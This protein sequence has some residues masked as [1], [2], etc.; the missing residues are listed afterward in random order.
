MVL[1]MVFRCTSHTKSDMELVMCQLDVQLNG[2]N[3]EV[4]EFTK[5]YFFVW[6]C[7]KLKRSY[8]SLWNVVYL[9]FESNIDIKKSWVFCFSIRSCD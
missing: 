5:L 9:Q 8:L 7:F 3:L 4:L 1:T 6:C 2:L